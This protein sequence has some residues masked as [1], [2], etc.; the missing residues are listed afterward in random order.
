[1]TGT[2]A[3]PVF[4]SISA[5]SFEIA[6]DDVKFPVL[7]DDGVLKWPLVVWVELKLLDLLLWSNLKALKNDIFLDSLESSLDNK[8]FLNP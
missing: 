2:T 3:S 6:A 5:E 4:G 7:D 8:P 1:M